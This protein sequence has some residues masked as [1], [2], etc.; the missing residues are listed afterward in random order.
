MVDWDDIRLFLS[1]A[2]AG[3]SRLAGRE[4]GI[5]QSTVSRRLNRLEA[6]AGVHLFERHPAGLR[7]SE[8]GHDFLDGAVRMEEEFAR[9]NAQVMGRDR[10]LSGQIRLSV[11]DMMVAPLA[12]ILAEFSAQYPA[13]ELEVIV[14]NGYANLTHREADVALRLGTSAPD[15]L[16]GRRIAPAS[17]AIYASPAYLAAVEPSEDLAR[18]DWIRWEEPWRTIPPERWMD[19]NV[20]GCRVVARVNTNL[21][22]VELMAAGAGLGFQLCYT[23]DADSRLT[24]VSKPFDFGLYVW[25][26]THPE[27]KSTARIAAFTAFVA[28]ALSVR[29]DRFVG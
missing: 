7:L 13:V 23:A 15:H 10:R 11:P 6:H 12:G 1:V 14:E 9:L 25:L 20:A 2:R 29:Q 16:V 22:M 8:A 26:L 3:T 19:D 18:L 21:A 4:L 5:S 24:R 27:L 28:N 17:A